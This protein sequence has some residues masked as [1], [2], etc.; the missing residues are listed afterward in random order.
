M[1]VLLAADELLR[2]CKAYPGPATDHRRLD[3]GVRGR[4]VR[5]VFRDINDPVTTLGASAADQAV[6][7]NW[8]GQVP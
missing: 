8:Q 6:L 7:G 1:I 4:S 2:T 3:S 5:N